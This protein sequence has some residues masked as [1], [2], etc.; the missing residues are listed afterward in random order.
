MDDSFIVTAYCIIS[1]TLSQLGH[2]THSLAK[3]G[4]AEVLTVAVV[5]AKFFGNH[6]E[7][8]LCVMVKAGYI[9]SLSVSR[10]NRRV[11]AL[12]AWLE[13]V[14]SILGQ[15]FTHQQVFVIDSI[16]LPVCKRVRARR[17]KKVRGKAFC[18]YCAAKKEKFFGW[19]LHLICDAQG[20]PVSYSVIE[21]SY[22]DLTPLHELSYDLPSGA[23]LYGDKGYLS[24]DDQASLQA[25]C[26]VVLV[27]PKRKNMKEQNTL[28][29]VFGLQRYRKGIE[30]V[31][32]QLESMGVQRLRARTNEG[33]FI[34][35]R[36]SLLALICTNLHELD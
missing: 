34:K 15:L 36:A 32:S 19:R 14:L 8:A 26:G 5:A 33:F 1:D 9:R 10:Y 4:D 22:H 23:V 6:Q 28:V 16:P 2:Q 20:V 13:G 17:C 21:A 12:T 3:V 24:G 18:G 29:E 27:T 11:H 25:S 31:N 30:T 35:V 7:R